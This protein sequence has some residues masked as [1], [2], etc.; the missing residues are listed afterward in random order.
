MK[1]SLQKFAIPDA[2][3]FLLNFVNSPRRPGVYR[4]IHVS[5]CPFICGNLPIRMHVPFAEH[6]GY[7]FLGEIRVHQRQRNAVKC[8]VPCCIPRVL[9]FVGH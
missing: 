4:W 3:T 9:P 1:H 6:E 5:K 8:Q 2:S 7:L